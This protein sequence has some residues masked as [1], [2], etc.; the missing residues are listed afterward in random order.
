M[1]LIPVNHKSP[2]C[3]NKEDKGGKIKVRF[4]LVDPRQASLT[5]NA[6]R[7]F[8]FPWAPPVRKSGRGRGRGLLR[9]LLKV[10]FCF[11]ISDIVH[12]PTTAVVAA[13]N[14]L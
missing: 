4:I 1:Q 9:I 13:K 2:Y 12:K 11:K 7:Y 3:F 14:L 10:V 8:K 5:I 6:T